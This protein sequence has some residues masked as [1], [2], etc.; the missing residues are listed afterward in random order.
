[1]RRLLE[2]AELRAHLLAALEDVVGRPEPVDG[3]SGRD[4]G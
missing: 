2:D 3:A 1:M 4:A